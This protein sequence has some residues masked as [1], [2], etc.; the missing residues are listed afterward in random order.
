MAA[1]VIA[2]A[3]QRGLKI[4]QD[5]S[6][7]GFDDTPIATAIWPQL[8]TIRQPIADMAQSAVTMLSESVAGSNGNGAKQ[9][10]QPPDQGR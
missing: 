6:V 2:M 10:D 4:P 5:L 8:T 3:H 7:V 1:G 9:R